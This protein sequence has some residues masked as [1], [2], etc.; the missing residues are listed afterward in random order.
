MRRLGADDDALRCFPA[1]FLAPIRPQRSQPAAV[2]VAIVRM[3]V[4]AQ[5]GVAGVCGGGWCHPVRPNLVGPAVEWESQS[6]WVGPNHDPGLSR[7]VQ[8]VFG[9]F[10]PLSGGFIPLSG[11]FI[12]LSGGFIPLSGGFIPSFGGCIPLSGGFVPLFRC[13]GR[14]GTDLNRNLDSDAR[15]VDVTRRWSVARGGNVPRPGLT[16]RARMGPSQWPWLGF[17]A[18]CREGGQAA[19]SPTIGAEAA[20]REGD[21]AILH[22][23]CTQQTH[24]SRLKTRRLGDEMPPRPCVSLIAG[25]RGFRE[26][27]SWSGPF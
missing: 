5:H 7:P 1:R 16:L 8:A 22:G 10:I 11:G 24:G 18:F 9:G 3:Q 4:F 19:T 15:Q 20:C 12:P 17:V 21:H 25:I 27:R 23:P 14:R 13:L 2:V 26:S 6:G